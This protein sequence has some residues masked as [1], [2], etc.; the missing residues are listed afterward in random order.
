MKKW[1]DVIGVPFKLSGYFYAL[2]KLARI[3]REWQL[4]VCLSLYK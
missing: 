3:L 2:F 1:P 4:G